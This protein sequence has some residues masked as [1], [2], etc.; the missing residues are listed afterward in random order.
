MSVVALSLAT[1]LTL[2]D[3]KAAAR[4]ALIAKGAT[5]TGEHRYR[6]HYDIT[7]RANP[8]NCKL[9]WHKL[10]RD[11]DRTKTLVTAIGK[12]PCP[13]LTFKIYEL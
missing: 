12:E 9:D 2:S 1:A 10:V 7:A 4:T 3:Y 6:Y 5:I 13:T 11:I 8:P